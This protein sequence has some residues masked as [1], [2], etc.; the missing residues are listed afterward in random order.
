MIDTDKRWKQFGETLV[1]YCVSLKVGERIIIAMGEPETWPLALAVYE[2][3]V[4]AGG[5][6]QI[7]MKSEHLRRAFMK[8][9]NEEQYSWAP[10]LELLS[11][12]WAD[13]YVALRGGYNLDIYHDISAEILAKNQAAHGL[14]SA[15]RTEKTR[16]VL[17]RVPNEAFA[18]QAG[19]DLETITDMYF[20]SVLLDYPLVNQT[21]EQ[22]VKKIEGSEKVHIT[23]KNTD[24]EFVARDKQ[25]T[26]DRAEFNI[27]GGEIANHVV[28]ETLNGCI[29]FENP[30]VLAGKL[31]YDTFLEWKNGQ[32]VRAESSTNQDYLKRII[33]TDKGSSLLGEYA[34]GTNPGLTSF[35]NDILWDEKIYGTIHVA[36]GRDYMM[37]KEKPEN[38]SKIHWDIV[39]DMRQQGEVAIDGVTILRDGQLLFNLL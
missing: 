13:C 11:I 12:D 31:M 32:L 6:P 22:W 30:A 27:P 16:W 15:E 36:L 35:T 34:F 19:M 23:G 2:A 3:G 29:Y 38:Y 9:G 18:Q 10:E 33:S 24:L 8:Y 39:K 28:N 21:L 17:T 37:K 1:N 14:V 4:K 25:W 5:H 26:I 20:E 7:Q